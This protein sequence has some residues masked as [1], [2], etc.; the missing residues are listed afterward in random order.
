MSDSVSHKKKIKLPLDDYYKKFFKELLRKI[1]YDMT[2]IP[3]I[4]ETLSDLALFERLISDPKDRLRFRARL[5]LLKQRIQMN[6][7]KKSA[8]KHLKTLIQL[9]SVK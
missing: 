4:K 9:A 3:S 6:S 2:K 8:V 1:E 7:K 5:H